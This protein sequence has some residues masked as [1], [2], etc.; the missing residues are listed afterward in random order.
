MNITKG[1]TYNTADGGS[2]RIIADDRK[3]S[4]GKHWVGL[5][6][7]ENGEWLVTYDADG[8]AYVF[9]TV[10]PDLSIAPEKRKFFLASYITMNGTIAA[11]AWKLSTG[12]ET[13]RN[14]L[15]QN[16]CTDVRITLVEQ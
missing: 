11:T 9:D 7:G 1:K 6:D 12:E 2:V 3:S 10:K 16:G 5:Y 4:N 13:I 15:K 8:T 14:Y